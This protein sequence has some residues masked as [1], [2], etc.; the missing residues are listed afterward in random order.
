MRT[1]M[2]ATLL[3]LAFALW[4]AAALAQDLMGLSTD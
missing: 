2:L 4:G 1:K 3:T